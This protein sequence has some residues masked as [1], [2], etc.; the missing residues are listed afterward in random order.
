MGLFEAVKQNITVRQVAEM[1]GFKPNRSGLIR[2]ILHNDKSPSM[3]VDRRYYCFGCGATGDVIDF[4]GHLFGLNAKD[5]AMKLAQDFGIP[6][7]NRTRSTFVK[8]KP[9][10]S[11]KEKWM[12][13][14]NRCLRAYLNYRTVL[15]E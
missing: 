6:Y 7:S 1:Y 12:E 9:V 13:E 2:C 14:Y 5:A 11:S 15:I 8:K 3:K 10:Q 4:A